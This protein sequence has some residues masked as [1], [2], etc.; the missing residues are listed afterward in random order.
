MRLKQGVF[1]AALVA[2]MAGQAAWAAWDQQPN[3]YHVTISNDGK[4]A[5]VKAD[6]YVQGN[7]LALFGVDVLPTLKNGQGDFLENIQ[8]RDMAGKPVALKD[9]GEAEYELE[10]GDRR[11]ALTYEVRLDHAKYHWPGG[12]EEVLY[13]TDEGIM[14]VGNSLFL[15]PGVAMPGK[16]EVSFTLPPGWK[17]QTPWL[18]GSK[19]G[20]FVAET[21]R[22]LVSNAMFLGTAH[23]ERFMAGGVELTLVMGKRYWPQKA[24]FID[25]MRRQL[26]A[27]QTLFGGPPRTNRY[28]VVIN[29]GA[30]SDGGAF[31]GSFSQIIT[32]DADI[33]SRVIWGRIVAHELLHFWNGHTLVPAEPQDEWFKEGVTDYLTLVTLVRN[34][35]MDRKFLISNLENLPRGQGVA[36]NLMGLKGT[37]RDAVKDK[38]NSWLLVYGGGT[39]AGLAMDVELRKATGGK[40]GMPQLMQ[41]LFAEFGQSGKRY[42]QADIV[43]HGRQ[44]AGIDLQ[45]TLERIVNS[46]TLI[47]MEPLLR[48]IGLRLHQFG[49]LETYLLPDPKATP[50]ARKRFADIFGMPLQP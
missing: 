5:H 23:S 41:S 11:L 36:R 1:G 37:V 39:I 18:A 2:L 40:V 33:S 27:Y 44:L 4:R 31:A 17:A 29:D 13:H 21:R 26:A 16:T 50:A 45:P 3:H 48:D 34:K 24:L 49:M 28:L 30:V 47:D 38:H 8:V 25:L 7:E 46:T 20:N 32:G 9:K 10:E 35:V 15:V 43:R 12:V 14:A 42:T 6:V 22:E 19:P